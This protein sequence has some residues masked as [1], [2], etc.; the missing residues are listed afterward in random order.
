MAAYVLAFETLAAAVGPSMA[1]RGEKDTAAT[2]SIIPSAP[3]RGGVE[4]EAAATGRCCAL[5]SSK[6]LSARIFRLLKEVRSCLRES[7]SI[8]CSSEAVL[9]AE[10]NAL[11]ASVL[12]HS[13][14]AEGTVGAAVAAD[15]GRRRLSGRV[16]ARAASARARSPFGADATS[17]PR[18]WPRREEARR[19]PERRPERPPERLN[20]LGG[21][22][23][24]FNIFRVVAGR[25]G[26]ASTAARII[27]TAA[28]IFSA[29]AIATNRFLV[30]ERRAS[31][32]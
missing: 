26:N 4:G 22:T 17:F 12:R 9:L 7:A 20:S 18:S 19:R 14:R 24:I 29:V 28:G 10:L 6:T 3:S 1:V 16:R 21:A 32:A 15:G 23:A 25:R 2:S 31:P 8:F 5:R 30:Q 27:I 13:C 11:K